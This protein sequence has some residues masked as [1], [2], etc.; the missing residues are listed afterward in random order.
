MT[1]IS[2]GLPHRT[3]W[4]HRGR[5]LRSRPSGNPA[6]ELSGKDLYENL[7]S[8]GRRARGIHNGNGQAAGSVAKAAESG[9]IHLEQTYTI[10]YIAHAPL[11]PRAAVA[12]WE[13]GKLTV[14]TGSQRPF[15][16]RDELARAFGVAA[17][18]SASDRT[19]HRSWLRG[20]AHGRGSR[21]G[22]PAGPRSRQAGEGSCG[23]ERKSL[24]G[25]ISGRRA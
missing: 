7:K 2:S 25:P 18:G 19:R 16:V 21:R 11:E 1:E 10:A 14:W 5:S 24:P 23:L 22:G 9:D 20:Q 8:Q 3:I 13:D 17:D 6:L 4:S 15:G 12:R